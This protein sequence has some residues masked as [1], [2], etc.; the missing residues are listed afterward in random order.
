MKQDNY[1]NTYVGMKWEDVERE[2]DRSK[3]T[4]RIVHEDGVDY[5]VTMDLREDRW[6]FFIE[7][8]IVTEAYTG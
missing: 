6:N 1:Q 8:G 4:Y 2:M 5:I 3:T 7:N